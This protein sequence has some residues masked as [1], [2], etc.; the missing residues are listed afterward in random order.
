MQTVSME[1]PDTLDLSISGIN[2]YNTVKKLY[3]VCEVLQ[4]LSYRGFLCRLL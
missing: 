1:Q 4:S 3:Q 2:V